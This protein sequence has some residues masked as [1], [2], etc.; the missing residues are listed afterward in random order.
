MRARL[1]VG[2]CA[3]TLLVVPAAEAATWRGETRQGRLAEVVTGDDGAIVQVRIKYRARC[4]D[5]KGYR[6]GVKFV[7]PLD[8]AST[9]AF[10]DGGAIE[11]NFKGGERAKGRTSVSGGLRSSGRWTGDFRLRVEIFR[12]GR[13]VA[14]CRTGRIGWKASPV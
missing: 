6:A 1:I 10:R 12:N 9:T 8:E 5:N 14:T 2:A 13:H 4:S 11:W 7:P 3:A